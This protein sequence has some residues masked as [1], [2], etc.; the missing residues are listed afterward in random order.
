[1]ICIQNL[2]KTKVRFYDLMELNLWLTLNKNLV[3]L[4]LAA[5][6]PN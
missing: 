2:Y 4:E 1:M 5:V 6:S 3:W